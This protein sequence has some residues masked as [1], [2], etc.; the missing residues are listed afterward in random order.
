MRSFPLIPLFFVTALL[1]ASRASESV[2]RTAADLTRIAIHDQTPGA[3]FEFTCRVLTD[4]TSNIWD[5]CVEDA[6][7][8][9]I[10]R[11]MRKAPETE[12]HAGDRIRAHGKILPSPYGHV[13][14]QCSFIE[15]LSHDSPEPVT[16][17]SGA[18]FALGKFD[19]RPIRITGTVVDA[20]VDD[21]DRLYT[22][23]ILDCDGVVVYAPCMDIGSADKILGATVSVRGTVHPRTSGARR[24]IGR[25]LMIPDENALT[26]LRP[27]GKDPFKTPVLKTV[28]LT[29]PAEAQALGRRRVSG[30]VLARWQQ[31]NILLRTSDGPLV[32]CDIACQPVP[33]IGQSIDVTGIVDT[34]LF[35]LVLCCATWRPSADQ[36]MPAPRQ[37]AIT[38]TSLI[39]KDTGIEIPD[40]SLLG[41]VVQLRGIVRNLPTPDN[42]NG[43]VLIENDGHLVP[44]D[45]SCNMTALNGLS[46]GCLASVTGVCV[47]DTDLWRQNAVFPRV[48]GYRIVTR[49]PQD[50]SIL[51]RP[52][53]WTT[54]R[55]IAAIGIL[56]VLL[57][58]ILAWNVIL[59]RLVESRGREIARGKVSQAESAA[60]VQERTRLAV[61][62]HDSVA[63]NLT[64]VSLEIRAA[65]RAQKEDPA[66][67]DKHLNLATR[68]LDSCRE[69]LRN[70]L[71]DLRNLALDETTVDEALRRT[72]QQHVGDRKLLLRF[73][74]PRE[75]FSDN[76]IHTILRIVRELV[77][78]AIR[79][80]QADE[81]KVAGSVDGDRLLFSVRDNGHGF[82]PETVPGMREGHFGLQGIRDRIGIFDGKMT[83]DSAPGQG[84]RITVTMVLPKES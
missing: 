47:F 59:R 13:C 49:V 22:H 62:L 26:V 84:A 35:H 74:V 76:T 7:G 70:C 54:G 83:I 65:R 51:R 11:Q 79:H 14:A 18:D 66:R 57:S 23:L 27:A 31:R 82:N 55:L 71:W 12:V 46:V 28:E 6:S 16:E 41:H 3:T 40:P 60:K 4:T 19:C 29:S 17:A 30:T 36:G 8:A 77:I 72:L 56:L 2:I 9:T 63:Q 81:I 21:I 34:D 73:N 45:A 39:G 5:F 58:G 42:E 20:F 61:E 15:R 1:P 53:W 43:I 38:P 52:P 10:L 25:T 68:S 24:H 69:E 48:R 80:G 37:E 78:N 33:D 67:M 32:T 64:G 75:K 50:I 44:V